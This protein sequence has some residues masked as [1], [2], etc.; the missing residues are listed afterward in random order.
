MINNSFKF[1]LFLVFLIHKN[2]RLS[3]RTIFDDTFK[4]VANSFSFY[5]N[6]ILDSRSNWGSN[7]YE[8]HR[9]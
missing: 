7:H 9:V 3:Q 5:H 8:L 1:L 4:E 2:Y 6:G